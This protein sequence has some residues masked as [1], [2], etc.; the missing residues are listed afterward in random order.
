LAADAFK[1]DMVR[2][3]V[4][5]FGKQIE[6]LSSM[7]DAA[8][9]KIQAQLKTTVQANAGLD[10]KW[11]SKVFAQIVAKIA[12]CRAPQSNGCCC[13]SLRVPRWHATPQGIRGLQVTFMGGLLPAGLER[14]I[15]CDPTR[16]LQPRRDRGRRVDGRV[17]NDKQPIYDLVDS[18][19]RP[20]PRHRM[21]RSGT[22]LRSTT[23]EAAKNNAGELRIATEA[24]RDHRTVFNRLG[25]QDTTTGPTRGQDPHRSRSRRAHERGACHQ[26]LGP[27]FMIAVLYCGRTS[28]KNALCRVASP[29]PPTSSRRCLHATRP[30]PGP[31]DAA[32]LLP[33]TA[34]TPGGSW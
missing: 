22:R 15:V 2:T 26:I 1:S 23:P 28:V 27:D 8:R 34:G 12:A 7:A 20:P 4:G 31:G 32:G 11:A 14:C 16:R 21:R 17:R 25:R 5:A 29:P 33:A 13:C 24:G 6:G 9:S 10:F 30:S 3:L 19:F 18:T